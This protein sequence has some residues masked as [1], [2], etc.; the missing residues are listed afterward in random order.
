MESKKKISIVGLVGGI[1]ALIGC[2]LPFVSAKAYGFS[3]QFSFMD[4]KKLFDSIG[5][6]AS[7]GNIPIEQQIALNSPMI[8]IVAC[9]ISIICSIVGVKVISRLAGL[10]NIIILALLLFAPVQGTNVAQMISSAGVGIGLVLMILGS[11]GM[12]ISA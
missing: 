1:V 4:V 9:I 6:L 11:I 8:F 2:F 5:A 7:F 10:V 3:A 12:L